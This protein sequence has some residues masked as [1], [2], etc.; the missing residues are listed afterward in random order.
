MLFANLRDLGSSIVLSGHGVVSS[1]KDINSCSQESHQLLGFK[2]WK[3]WIRKKH[4][5]YQLANR[6]LIAANVGEHGEMQTWRSQLQAACVS[7][8][9]S[10][11]L[12]LNLSKVTLI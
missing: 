5:T 10:H 2:L 11:I 7:G 4:F 1:F 12:S 3:E 9:S 8:G 6:A